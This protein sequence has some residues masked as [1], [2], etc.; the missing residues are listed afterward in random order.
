MRF[1]FVYQIALLAL[2][3]STAARVA[4]AQETIN[5]ASIGGRATDAA[6]AV[7]EGATATRRQT[8]ST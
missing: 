7:I 2:G 8:D 3:A 6:G 1:R 4:P 5:Y